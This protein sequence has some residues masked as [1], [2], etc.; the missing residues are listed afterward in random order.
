MGKVASDLFEHKKSTYLLLV[1]YF[2][3]F[4]EIEKLTSTTSSN[5]ITHLKAIFLRHGIPATLIIDNG[6]Q[7]SSEEMKQSSS[8]YGM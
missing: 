3:R 5:V 4:V 1:D 8:T 6:P 7:Y 2:S